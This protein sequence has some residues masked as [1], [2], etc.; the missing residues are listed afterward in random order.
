MEPFAAWHRDLL[1]CGMGSGT[2]FNLSDDC[3]IAG[4]MGFF[5]M[6]SFAMGS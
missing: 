5:A 4:D 3:G 2:T 1:S 6:G